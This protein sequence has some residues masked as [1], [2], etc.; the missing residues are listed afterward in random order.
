MTFAPRRLTARVA[1]VDCEVYEPTGMRGLVTVKRFAEV[2]GDAAIRLL[3]DGIEISAD[4]ERRRVTA[5]DLVESPDAG[6]ILGLVAV[7]VDAVAAAPVASIESLAANLLAGATI[8]GTRVP[9]SP[10]E[11]AAVLAAVPL[12]GLGMV[13]LIGRC[14]LEF[15]VPTLP[16]ADTSAHTSAG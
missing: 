6:A 8:G 5:L 1:G 12:S 16:A 10:R 15:L 7:C 13:E 3:S 14:A 4:G 9:S 11:A 2:V